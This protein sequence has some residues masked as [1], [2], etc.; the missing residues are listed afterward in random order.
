MINVNLNSGSFPDL[1]TLNTERSGTQG[2]SEPREDAKPLEQQEDDDDEGF[3]N[4][5]EPANDD[6]GEFTEPARVEGPESEAV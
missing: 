5:A 1:M 3:G 4:W 6:F 2:A